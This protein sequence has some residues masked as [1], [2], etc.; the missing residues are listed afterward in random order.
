MASHDTEATLFSIKETTIP[1]RNPQSLCWVG[2]D[3]VD[4]VNGVTY[5]LDGSSE[6]TGGVLGYRFD[7]AAVSPSGRYGVVYE[8]RGTKGVVWDLTAPPRERKLREI[9]R[10]FDNA[11]ASEYPVLLFAM[12]DGR[13]AIAHCPDD[14]NCLLIEDLRDAT[15]IAKSDNELDYYFSRL[16]IS[17]SGKRIISTGWFWH[18]F[19]QMLTFDT[20]SILKNQELSTKDALLGTPVE[21]GNA[22]FLSDDLL[23]V[24]GSGHSIS[25]EESWLPKNGL[26][27]YD[28]AKGQ[29]VASLPLN[30]TLG[31][32]MPI[33]SR[34]VVEFY[35][36]PKL[37]DLQAG[38][39]VHQWENVDSG[40][41]TSCLIGNLDP[42][43]TMALDQSHGRFA[44]VD[45]KSIRVV[46]IRES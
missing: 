21:P 29:F 5:R 38:K 46:A 19:I 3:L 7:A 18:P 11:D 2:D 14:Y 20:Q 17:P 32:L 23:I 41:Q 28:L 4:L 30:R 16:A 40:K 31:T 9:N 26:A 12:P 24:S 27:V 15:L 10:S 13:E 34:L 6:R 36:H 33:S 22:A 1:A 44:V 8:R 37:I 42:L 39:T 45:G 35:E 25:E 43:P